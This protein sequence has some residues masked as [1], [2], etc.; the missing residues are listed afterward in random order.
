M[1]V[2]WSTYAQSLTD[3]VV[4]GMLTGPVTILEWSFVHDDQPRSETCRQIALAVMSEVADLE[5]A[6][7]RA[8]QIDEPAVREG[9]PLRRSGWT[10]GALAGRQG[11]VCRR[12]APAEGPGSAPTTSRSVAALRPSSAGV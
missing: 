6:G 10:V 3:Q 12:Q 11:D 5:K 9:L 7:L 2:P 1:T 4:K 8:I